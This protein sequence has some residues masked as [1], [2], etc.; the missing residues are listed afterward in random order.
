MIKGKKFVEPKA[1]AIL[2]DWTSND[3]FEHFTR[4]KPRQKSSQNYHVL[5]WSALF[6]IILIFEFY[7]YV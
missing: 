6:I 4:S 1:Q 3:S 7:L 5:L 2:N